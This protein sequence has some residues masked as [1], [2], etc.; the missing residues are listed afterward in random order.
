[1]RKSGTLET[2]SWLKT[3]SSRPAP[4]IGKP[5]DELSFSSVGRP[6]IQFWK[7]SV[8]TRSPMATRVTP[9]PTASTTPQPSEKGVITP[10]AVD[11]PRLYMPLI[12][13]RSR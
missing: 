8:E 13:R 7:K 6:A 2:P 4:G 11:E 5:R 3:A 1:M 10:D 12:I 9:G